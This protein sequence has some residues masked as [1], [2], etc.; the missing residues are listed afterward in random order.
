MKNTNRRLLDAYPGADGIKTGYTKAAGFSL[1]SSAHRGNQRVIVAMLGGQVER[2]AQRRGGATHGCRLRQ[3]AGG[4]QAP[5]AG[6]AAYRFGR[7]GDRGT[8][9]DRCCRDGDNSRA[10]N[11][12]CR[13][14]RSAAAAGAG[15]RLDRSCA[16]QPEHHR[17]DRRGERRTR[18]G[19]GL[20]RRAE[21]PR[22]EWPP[23]AASGCRTRR[24]SG[25]WAP[26][27]PSPS[28]RRHSP[29]RS[30][31]ISRRCRSPARD[32]APLAATTGEFQLGAFRAKGDAERQLLTTA[33]RD[34]R[35]LSGG[36]RRVEAA[37]VQGV[38][39]YRAQF[40]GLTQSDALAACEALA[41]VKADCL[42]L[43]PGI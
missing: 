1:V 7:T 12:A 41:R 17:G 38:T 29:V 24:P 11:A 14:G 5:G 35:Q 19:A 20:A 31:R 28:L 6:A 4:G 34:V 13:P 33:L 27:R 40:V 42:P 8:R 36:L 37:K 22:A 18:G 25:S 2:L 26:R 3:D 10:C 32:P 43:A 15:G 39:I 16:Q 30:S 23:G 9:I 21:P